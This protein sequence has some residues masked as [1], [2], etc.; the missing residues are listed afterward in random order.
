M[1]Y[2]YETKNYVFNF[3]DKECLVR[4]FRRFI[5]Y[6]EENPDYPYTDITFENFLFRSGSLTIPDHSELGIESFERRSTP[7]P[8]ANDIITGTNY[9]QSYFSDTSLW[10]VSYQNSSNTIN[11]EQINSAGTVNIDSSIP[12]TEYNFNQEY[13]GNFIRE[14]EDGRNRTAN[15]VNMYREY[16]QEYIQNYINKRLFK[17]NKK[18]EKIIKKLS[19]FDLLDI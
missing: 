5:E 7:L 10:T 13:Y 9:G 3:R 14:E 16:S 17:E 18:E 8:I 6:L 4:S 1:S 15:E 19:R 11:A 12:F 2:K